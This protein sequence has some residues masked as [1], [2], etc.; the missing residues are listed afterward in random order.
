[1]TKLP[2]RAITQPSHHGSTNTTTQQTL[3]H[4][5]GH[6]Y[7]LHRP[8]LGLKHHRGGGGGGGGGGGA[9]HED[10]CD[11]DS[12]SGPPRHKQPK[13]S[14]S[15]QSP[16]QQQQQSQSQQP[17]QLEP[18]QQQHQ[19]QQQPMLAAQVPL[20]Q[21]LSSKNLVYM[22]PSHLQHHIQRVQHHSPPSLNP[23]HPHQHATPQLRHK[24][25]QQQQS[26]QNQIPHPILTG[27]QQQQTDLSQ[28]QFESWPTTS[29]ISCLYPEIL[30]LIFSR[31]SVQDRGRAAQVCSA[32]REAAQHRS[33][34]RN[35]EARLHLRK[36]STPVFQCMERRGIK[37]VQIL[38]LTMRRG[39]GDVFRGLPKLQSLS[40]SGCYNMSDAG[41]NGALTGAFPSLTELNLSLCK[42]ITDASLA[43]IAQYM[44]NLEVLELGG[45]GNVS[46]SGLHVIAWGLRKLKRLDLRSCWHISD[47]GIGYVAGQ[48]QEA[49]GNMELE[50]L[51]L[52]DC[53]RLSDEG[54]RHLANGLG[55]TL[56][57]INL[58]FCVL[59]TDSGMKHVAK[60][61]SLRELNLRS[62]DN[63]SEIGMAYLA[64]GNSKI[65][66]LDVSFCDKVGDQALQNISQGLYNLR[67]LSL[68][69]CPI[70]D[71]GIHKISKNQQ[72]LE[73]L[74]IGQCS[75]L[76]DQSVFSIV[77]NMPKIRSIDLYGCTRITKQGL[78][79]IW[80]LPLV[81]LNL[82]L[83]QELSR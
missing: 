49:E 35:V 68:S 58:S 4:R 10:D 71:E 60:I 6:C 9:D 39:L 61:Q 8:H 21:P 50:H 52:Q 42:N 83:W 7:Q 51:G 12:A 62:C 26:I 15:P 29:H 45:C 32:W 2:V 43:K 78:S 20:P 31:L 73:T 28:Q 41:L 18:N 53:Q 59:I 22:P 57:S 30:A 55:N 36:H 63:I 13:I 75:R 37:R 25:Q 40:L 77:E 48:S 44:K 3:I 24:Q 23:H 65:S 46:N 79:R 72:E 11:D 74:H 76:T 5:P 69:A 54:L 64:E 19:Q 27:G 16:P 17:P 38:S 80:N 1:M 33:V 70:S 34:W 14:E 56:K 67:S 82:G 66:S 47:V 81:S